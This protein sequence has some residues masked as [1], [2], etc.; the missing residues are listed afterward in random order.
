MKAIPSF[1]KK[2]IFY[3]LALLLTMVFGWFG[4]K[5]HYDAIGDDRGVWSLLYD[6]LRL[7]FLEHDFEKD[8]IPLL[9]NISRFLAPMLF[10]TALFDAFS[11]LIKKRMVAFIVRNYYRNHVVFCGLGL[12]TK[13]MVD[14]Y[15]KKSKV[16]VIEINSDNHYISELE[17]RKNIKVIKGDAN[18]RKILQQ[19]GILKAAKVHI[20]SGNDITNMEIAGTIQ[21]LFDEKQHKIKSIRKFCKSLPVHLTVDI[22]DHANEYVFKQLQDK[23]GDCVDVCSFNI[24]QKFAAYLAEKYAPDQYSNLHDPESNP[25]HILCCGS[26]KIIESFIAE[27]GHLYHFASFKKPRITLVGHDIEKNK[28][29]LMKQYPAIHEVVDMEFVPEE[30]FFKEE[31]GRYAD[32]FSLC[33]VSAESNAE[34]FIEAKKLRQWFFQAAYKQ[35]DPNVVISKETKQELLATPPIVMVMTKPTEVFGLFDNFN[36]HLN[37]LNISAESMLKE[38]FTENMLI[39]DHENIDGIARQIH[40]L[41][42]ALDNKSIDAKWDELTDAGKD[43]NRRAARHLAI[44]LRYLGLELADA[45]AEGDHVNLE[46]LGDDQVEILAKMEHNRWMAEK[47]LLGFATG[48]TMSD[49]VFYRELKANLKWHKDLKPWEQLDDAARQIDRALNDLKNVIGSIKHKKVIKKDQSGGY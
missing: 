27:A 30:E 43:Q 19:A 6:I 41:Y 47:R 18:D 45:D 14:M 5:E 39:Y 12:K 15:R 28:K 42:L 23:K 1:T 44:K 32:R 13:R 38:I 33:F 24:N 21:Q 11:S 22:T 9:L 35:M 46:H 37:K 10:A 2:P 36:D 29:S 48:A 7:F 31:P 26:E 25:P 8:K 17:L 49:K 20:T 3:F 40:D 34:L 16:V 4:F